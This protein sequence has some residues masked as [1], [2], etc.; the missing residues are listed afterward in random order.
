MTLRDTDTQYLYLINVRCD[1]YVN[2]VWERWFFLCLHY[3]LCWWIHLFSF[4]MWF[5]NRRAKL[6]KRIPSATLA[7]NSPSTIT[8]SLLPHNLVSSAS[9]PSH[10]FVNSNPPVGHTTPVS[11]QPM[12]QL[13]L[14]PDHPFCQLLQPHAIITDQSHGT[15]NQQLLVSKDERYSLNNYH[16]SVPKPSPDAY[17]KHLPAANQNVT[18]PTEHNQNQSY[19]KPSLFRPFED[20]NTSIRTSHTIPLAVHAPHQ[21]LNPM[22]NQSATQV[23][24]HPHHTRMPPRPFTNHM[25]SMGLSV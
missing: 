3:V 2:S 15:I 25:M 21:A 11:Y 5:Q 10:D 8:P 12:T 20:V 1:N 19:I 23:I 4:Q 22:L 9:F 18:P 6:R 17:I 16:N 13:A 7:H 24:P 14:P